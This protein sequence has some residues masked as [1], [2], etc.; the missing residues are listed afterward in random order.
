MHSAPRGAGHTLS[1]VWPWAACVAHGHDSELQA[2]C[3]G[4]QVW[5]EDLSGASR[6][7]C[8]PELEAGPEVH[9]GVGLCGCRR[10]SCP[11]QGL[12]G[13]QEG[14]GREQEGTGSDSNPCIYFSCSGRKTGRPWP[15]AAGQRALPGWA[16]PEGDTW[17]VGNE[18]IL[19]LASGHRHRGF[20]PS[21]GHRVNHRSKSHA[22]E[23]PCPLRPGPLGKGSSAAVG[24]QLG[25]LKNQGA[26]IPAWEAGGG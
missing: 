14:W 24:T 22:Q 12:A 25:P 11:V 5:A 1:Q 21:W 13:R 7:P 17:A 8:L 20:L 16:P 4:V 18:L 6:R 3:S 19:G 2:T 23:D 9:I 15:R 10:V 26:L